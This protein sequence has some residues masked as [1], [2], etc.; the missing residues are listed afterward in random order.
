VVPTGYAENGDRLVAGV[1]ALN[2][3][4]TYVL[5]IE[6]SRRTG[7]VIPKGGWEKD[8]ECMDA[9][10]REAWEEAGILCNIDYDLG[11]VTETRTA[12]QISKNAPKALYQ[13]F[14]AT[15][16]KEESEWP[17][18]KKRNRKWFTYTEAWEELKHRP[19]LAEA[20]RRSTLKR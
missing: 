18:K 4:K 7:W 8:E 10:K 11:Q 1:V 3:E 16:T 17:E 14:E 19:E 15:V 6:S 13:F 9:A 20:L 2:P 12:K 5:L